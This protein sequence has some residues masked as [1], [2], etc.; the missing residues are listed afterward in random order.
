MGEVATNLA[1]ILVTSV[2]FSSKYVLQN[3]PRLLK[4]SVVLAMIIYG[5][6]AQ[7]LLTKLSRDFICPKRPSPA[8]LFRFST[9]HLEQKAT[10][11]SSNSYTIDRLF[12]EAK[13]RDLVR[14]IARDR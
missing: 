14:E 7:M 12:E 13:S 8:V 9:I 4:I 6:S 3:Q 5:M 11:V 1:I 10:S 2:I